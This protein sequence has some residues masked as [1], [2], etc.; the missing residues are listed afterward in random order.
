MDFVKKLI[1]FKHPGC[2]CCLIKNCFS[3]YFQ[4]DWTMNLENQLCI[5]H[6]NEFFSS[7]LGRYFVRAKQL[8]DL[9]K[10]VLEWITEKNSS[11]N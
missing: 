2:R 1:Q 7:R 6:R 3:L 9:D 5:K 8:E 4:A 10:W 11:I